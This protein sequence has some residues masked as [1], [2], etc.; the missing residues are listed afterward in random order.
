MIYKCVV[1][2]YSPEV[3]KQGPQRS[4]LGTGDVT[5]RSLHTVDL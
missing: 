3:R 2:L 4:G 1:S 5:V